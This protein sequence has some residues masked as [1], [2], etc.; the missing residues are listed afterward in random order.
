MLVQ[1][2]NMRLFKIELI[3]KVK[4]VDNTTYTVTLIVE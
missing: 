1:Y 2:L 3:V 4:F